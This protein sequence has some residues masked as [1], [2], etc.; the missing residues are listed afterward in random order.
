MR[1]VPDGG[2]GAGE[3]SRWLYCGSAG[4]GAVGLG[5]LAPDASQQRLGSG[6]FF[7]AN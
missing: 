4:K 3:A 7:K 1:Y 6:G 2:Q 5:G